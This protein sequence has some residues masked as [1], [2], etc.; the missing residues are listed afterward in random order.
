MS[1]VIKNRR[2]PQSETFEEVFARRLDRR[3][4]LKNSL[5]AA[6]VLVV[7]SKLLTTPS[8]AAAADGLN[9]EPVPLSVADTVITPPD[10]STQVFLRW[11][12]PLFLDSPDFDP[13]NQTAESQMQQFGYNNDFLAFFPLPL[14][15]PG[16]SRSGILTVNHEYTNPELM[17]S[18]YNLSTITKEQVDIQLAA[19]GLSIIEISRS[20]QQWIYHRRSRFNRRITA[21]TRI[22]ITGP[23]AGAELLKTS[24]DP[25]GSFVFGTLNNCGGGKTPW[26]TLLTCEENFNQYFANAGRIPDSDPRKAM[27]SRYGLTTGASER[28]WELF[29]DR[30]DLTKEPNEPF[31]FGWVIELDPYDPSF[32]PKKRTAL[33]RFKHEAAT[34]VLSRHRNAVVYSGDDERFDYMYKFVSRRK[35]SRTNRRSNLRVLDDG[36]LF[37]ARFNDDGTGEWIPL[38]AGDGALAGSTND[39]VLI[40]TRLAADLVGATKMDRPEDI[41]VNPVNGKVY[42]VMTNNTNRGTTGRPGIDAANPRANNR[43]GHII[44]ITEDNGDHASRTFAWEIFVLAGDPN[45]TSGGVP[46]FAGFD[47]SRVSPI[48]S[49]DNI[50]F[51]KLG[52]LWIA[53]DGQPGTLQ[54]H[55]GIYA[56][57]V[58]GSDRGFVRQFLSSVV[59]CET[60]SLEL[61]PNNETLFVSIQHPGEGSTFESPSSTFPNGSSTP[62]PSVIAITKFASGSKTIG[63]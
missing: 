50:T 28:R 30:F 29:H 38:I 10:Y 35:V 36:I 31:R 33:G 19:H 41:E 47:T 17:F 34:V 11:G 24:Y 53:T 25:A 2:R 63:S 14:E 57:P 6:P 16:G 1:L 39:S 59:A 9:F 44:E 54:K 61:T 40:N 32:L 26:G 52:N 37:A 27:H 18:N 60:A 22:E 48:S 58:E 21:E 4:F 42:A 3:S 55:D 20:G 43:H 62:R 13:F 5:I 56:V 46:F 45:D 15:R 49:P 7:G 23:A 8:Q 51:D 12:D